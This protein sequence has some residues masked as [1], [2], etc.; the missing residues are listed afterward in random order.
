MH[1]NMFHKQCPPDY[2]IT[3]A[4]STRVT[5]IICLY[6]TQHNGHDELGDR[7]RLQVKQ[8]IDVEVA[9]PQVRTTE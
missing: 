8:E 3:L 7:L 9:P 2:Q 1:L 6:G 5:I 4:I